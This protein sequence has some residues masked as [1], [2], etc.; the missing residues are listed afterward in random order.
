MKCIIDNC[1]NEAKYKSG[2]CNTHYERMRLHGTTAKLPDVHYKHGSHLNPEYNAWRNLKRRCHDAHN[3]MYKHYGGRGIGVCM[4]WQGKHGFENFL[5]D[6]GPRPSKKHSI[7]RID[8]DKDYCP[9]NCR[10]ATTAEQANNKRDNIWVLY[11]GER[12]TLKD[13]SKHIDDARYQT[14]C[15]RLWR[16]VEVHP[17]IEVLGGGRGGGKNI[18]ANEKNENRIW[19]LVDGKKKMTMAEAA[20]ELGEDY[21]KI[22]YRYKRYG[23]LPERLQVIGG[24]YVR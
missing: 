22:H 9:E 2:L 14:L 12:M 11:K 13:A 3:P 6:M 18:L 15:R 16:G 24:K 21:H 7:D 1:Q 20:R 10:W 17:D 4:R 5:K 19:C 8:V 23:E